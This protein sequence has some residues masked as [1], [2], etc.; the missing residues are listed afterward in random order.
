MTYPSS[1]GYS[2]NTTSRAAAESLPDMSDMKQRIINILYNASCGRTVDELRV[3][4]ESDLK[5][6]FDRTTIGARM[7]E[8]VMQGYI[9]ETYETRLTPRNRQA[10]VYKIDR[11]GQSFWLNN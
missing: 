6:T 2:N 9:R 5:R 4:L 3:E 1:P 7:T 11:K 10:T 8:M